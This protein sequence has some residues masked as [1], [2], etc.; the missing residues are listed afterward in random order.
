MSFNQLHGKEFEDYIKA[1][2]PGSSDSSRGRDSFFDIEG[3]YDKIKKLP[4]SIKLSINNNIAMADA[5]KFYDNKKT[6]RLLIGFYKQMG[7][8]KNVEKAKVY[9][10]TEEELEIIKGGYTQEEIYSFHEKLKLFGPGQH[11]EAREFGS[12]EVHRLKQLHPNALLRLNPKV[13]SKNQRRLQCS[14]NL[15]DLEKVVVDKKEHLEEFGTL[16]FPLRIKSSARE[17]KSTV[18]KGESIS[19]NSKLKS[20]HKSKYHVDLDIAKDK[21]AK[22]VKKSQICKEYSCPPWYLDKLIRVGRYQ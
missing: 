6:M 3:R 19:A 10:I 7:N 17:L 21:I 20:T 12:Q 4:T 22:G 2:F 18:D 13:D 14:I 9:I 16:V 8:I 11:L 1:Q 15:S 5:R